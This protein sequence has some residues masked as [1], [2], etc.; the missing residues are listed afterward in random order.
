MFYIVSC[1][2]GLLSTTVQPCTPRASHAEQTQAY[3]SPSAA[4]QQLQTGV[5][6]Y[7]DIIV[8]FVTI[9]RSN[10]FPWF[11]PY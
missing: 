11:Q 9:S 5:T 3:I 8:G 1:P 7:R 6:R 4:M 2:L 10:K